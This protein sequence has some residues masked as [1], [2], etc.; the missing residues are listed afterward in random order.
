[1]IGLNWGYLESIMRRMGFCDMWINLMMICV[2]TV[3]Y[4]ILV[5]G[6]PQSLIQPTKGIR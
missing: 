1:M 5:N 3:T 4:L 2:K 6:E